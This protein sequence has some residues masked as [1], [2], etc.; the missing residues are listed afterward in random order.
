MLLFRAPAAGR[1]HRNQ[2]TNNHKI[3]GHQNVARLGLQSMLSRR[4]MNGGSKPPP[5]DMVIYISV[6]A[7]IGRPLHESVASNKKRNK[8]PSE[9]GQRRSRWGAAHNGIS[10]VGAA[11]PRVPLITCPKY[12][13]WVVIS[14][15][16]THRGASPTGLIQR[17]TAKTSPHP[18]T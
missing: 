12:L 13:T 15:S 4:F 9:G 17:F 5:Y 7:P 3:A 14:T 11:P 16:G 10:L 2:A 8:T 6:G 1:R 18:Y